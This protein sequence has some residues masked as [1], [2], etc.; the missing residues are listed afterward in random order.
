MES[1]FLKLW[2]KLGTSI[3]LLHSHDTLAFEYRSC[4]TRKVK[5]RK[6]DDFM[7]S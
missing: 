1:Y 2:E 7:Q 5:T 4:S 6:P 3:A